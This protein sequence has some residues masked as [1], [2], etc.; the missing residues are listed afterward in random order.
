MTHSIFLLLTSWMVSFLHPPTCQ[1][2]QRRSYP[3]SRH[4]LARSSRQPAVLQPTDS[5][6]PPIL[7]ETRMDTYTPP[8]TNLF[9]TLPPA[10]PTLTGFI[11]LAVLVVRGSGLRSESRMV[12]KAK[13]LIPHFPLHNVSSA[14]TNEDG[15]PPRHMHLFSS[16]PFS[17]KSKFIRR[18]NQTFPDRINSS[19]DR[20][21]G[22]P[23]RLLA[24]GFQGVGGG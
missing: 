19:R 17:D 14:N 9:W 3:P 22:H 6:S 13:I 12:D 5:F 4:L 24:L 15:N 18:S 11:P 21:I 2:C 20:P 23:F 10:H 1:T 8:W 7:H 16:S